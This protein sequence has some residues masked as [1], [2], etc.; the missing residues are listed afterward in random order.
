M[1]AGRPRTTCPEHDELIELGI[2]M[3]DWIKNNP[4]ALHLSAWYSVEKWITNDAWDKMV[5]KIEFRVYYEIAKSMIGQKYLDKTSNVR[6]NASQRWQRVYFKDLKKEENEQLAHEAELRK[7]TEPE[8]AIN[9]TIKNYS[10]KEI[11]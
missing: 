2:E 10:D 8:K 4:N 7:T 6:E 3:C 9:L 5:E 11:K 1:P